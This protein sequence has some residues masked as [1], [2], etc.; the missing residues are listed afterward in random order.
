MKIA[1]LIGLVAVSGLCMTAAPAMAQYAPTKPAQPTKD[2]PKEK[3]D[4]EIKEKEKELKE[5]VDGQRKD[6]E[7]QDGKG[8]EGVKVGPGIPAPAFS[9]PDTEGKTHALADA[10]KSG[11]VVVLQWFNAGCPF[12]KMHYGEKGNTFNDLHA[13]YAARGVEFFAVCSSAPG[14]QGAGK[15]YNAKIKT[16]W[17][18][19]YPI[20]L[21]ESGVVGMSYGAKN[22]PLMVVINK[23][24]TIAYYGA[25]D[26]AKGADGPGKVNYVAKALD[27]ILA[28]T[29]VTMPET[30]PYGCSVKYAGGR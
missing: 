25:I 23:E 3:I 10:L 5:K 18:V 16:D 6:K 9:L 11:K 21:D 30:K 17:K 26:D 22:T 4:K 27:E 2:A 28:G 1:S 13:K 19:P 24:G 20:L 7:K 8:K 14:L 12:V 15:E 29:N